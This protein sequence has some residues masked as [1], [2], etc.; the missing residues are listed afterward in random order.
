[1]RTLISILVGFILFSSTNAQEESPSPGYAF[2]FGVGPNLT[3]T[4]FNFDLAV[5][6]IVNENEHIRL[7][8]SPR[9]TVNEMDRGESPAYRIDKEELDD[10]SATV[11]AD[12]VWIVDKQGDFRTYAGLGLNYKYGYKLKKITQVAKLNP[13]GKT[14]EVTTTSKALG[15]RVFFGAEWMVTKIIGIHAEYIPWFSHNWS[16]EEKVGTLNNVAVSP[17]TVKYNDIY[18][19]TDVLF[20]VSIYF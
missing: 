7:F 9:V 3:L 11:G 5:K 20:G 8:F 1:M 10:Y 17:S 6:K 16:T 4:K 19:T 13:G 18:L 12:Y 14:E 15:A 2:T